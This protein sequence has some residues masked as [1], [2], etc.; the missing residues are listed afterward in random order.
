MADIHVVEQLVRASGLL[1]LVDGLAARLAAEGWLAGIGGVCKV[2]ECRVGL[3]DGGQVEELLAASPAGIAVLDANLSPLDVYA[4]PLID[5]IQQR[6][7]GL[8]GQSSAALT[9]LSLSSGVAALP[10]PQDVGSIA[11][12]LSLDCRPQFLSEA[13]ALQRLEELS[14]LDD[15]PDWIANLWKPALK[16]V[17]SNLR[18]MAPADIAL[19]LSV[20]DR[21]K[22]GLIGSAPA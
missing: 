3:T 6:I 11:I 2:L 4:R 16:R 19:A 13:D 1:L 15:A 14:E 17:L 21:P 12:K 7:A 20:I 8:G 9:V 18:A 5:A 10:V 22:D